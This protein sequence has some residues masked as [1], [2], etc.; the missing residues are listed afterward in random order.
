[1]TRIF[2]VNSGVATVITYSVGLVLSIDAT[3]VMAFE[4]LLI[5]KSFGQLVTGGKSVGMLRPASE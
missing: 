4:V 1:M 2:T 5:L 3:T